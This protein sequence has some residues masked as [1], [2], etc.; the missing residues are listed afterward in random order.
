[1]NR[2]TSVRIVGRAGG[3]GKQ[4]EWNKTAHA[5]GPDGDADFRKRDDPG[6]R[7]RHTA[8]IPFYRVNRVAFFRL[9]RVQ[10]QLDQ[11][12]HQRRQTAMPLC[13]HILGYMLI[14]VKPG[15]VLIS[16]M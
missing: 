12:I 6:N 15:I 16:L 8:V 5:I 3:E 10:R 14:D 1:M 4:E 7:A 9:C 13:S 2:F 11:P